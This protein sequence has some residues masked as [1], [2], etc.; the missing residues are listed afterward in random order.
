MQ[1]ERTLRLTNLKFDVSVEAAD[2]NAKIFMENGNNLQNVMNVNY[3]TSMTPGSEF[4]Q[5][6]SIKEILGFHRDW[7]G[8][9]AI[10]TKDC[11]YPIEDVIYPEDKRQT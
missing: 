4:R 9:H 1:V 5:I 10:I 7:I 6:S 2:H 11:T 8:T 3:G